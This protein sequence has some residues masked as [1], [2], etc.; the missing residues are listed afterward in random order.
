MASS[1]NLYLTQRI[2]FIDIG[3]WRNLPGYF[4]GHQCLHRCRQG[5]SLKL[6]THTYIPKPSICALEQT[7]RC[8]FTQ[9]V[10]E[11]QIKCQPWMVNSPSLGHMGSHLPHSYPK[12]SENYPIILSTLDIPEIL[13]GVSLLCFSVGVLIWGA[14]SLLLPPCSP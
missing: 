1:G 12:G 5:M 4:K 11:K 2:C 10:K 13:K 9:V 3:E 14:M 6:H 8:A 7:K